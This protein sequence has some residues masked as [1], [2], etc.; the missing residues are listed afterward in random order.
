MLMPGVSRK[1]FLLFLVDLDDINL[2]SLLPLQ[3]TCA[4]FK[5]LSLLGVQADKK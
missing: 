5:D 2:H 4:I 3:Y 1:L